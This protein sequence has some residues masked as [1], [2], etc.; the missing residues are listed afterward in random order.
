MESTNGGYISSVGAFYYVWMLDILW[1]MHQYE[2]YKP[3]Y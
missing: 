1:D 3:I 2:R